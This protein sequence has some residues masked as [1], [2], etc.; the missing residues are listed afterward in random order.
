MGG[1][2]H[3]WRWCV[4]D[5]RGHFFSLPN[6]VFDLG[7]SPGEFAVY[8]FLRR[9]ADW[10]THQCYPSYKTIGAAVGMSENTVHKYICALADK[11]LISTE[12]TTVFTKDGMKRNGTLLYTIH[13]PHAV[14]DAQHQQLLDRLE[15]STARWNQQLS[16]SKPAPV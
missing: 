10:K 3:K 12:N 4:I 15:V 14:M 11:G 6:N 1:A 16:A 8:S 13:D 9:C 7:L 2:T 5:K